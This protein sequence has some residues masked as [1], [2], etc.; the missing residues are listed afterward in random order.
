MKAKI[1]MFVVLVGFSAV[2][3]AQTPDKENQKSFRGQGKEMRMGDSPR[4]HEFGLNLN[5]A[6][7]ES[8]KKGMLEMHKLLQP[9]RN[10]LGEVE[11]HQ[12]TLM[13]AEKP[14]LAA[15]NKNIEKIGTIKIEMA[16]I[17]AKNRVEMRAQLTDEQRL[18][19]DLQKEKMM[20]GK[21]P[22]GMKDGMRPERKMRG[23][24][25]DN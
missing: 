5:D 15:I 22:R 17:Q 20:K 19:F 13:M 7:K 1:L 9:L 16:K 11:A 4:G 10:E 6:Q 23:A 8:F 24:K 21:G 12:K 18:K 25:S 14:D 2:L 3:Y